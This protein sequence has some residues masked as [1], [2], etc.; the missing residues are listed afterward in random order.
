MCYTL[1]SERTLL[2]GH[3]DGGS[4]NLHGQ[5]GLAGFDGK[6]D[7]GSRLFL[8]RMRREPFSTEGQARCTYL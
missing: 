8:D 4:K 6:Y 2:L 3:S 5:L 7:A 1:S